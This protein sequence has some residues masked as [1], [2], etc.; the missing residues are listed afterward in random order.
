MAHMTLLVHPLSDAAVRPDHV[1]HPLV[2]FWGSA[3]ALRGA[4]QV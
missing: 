2:H 4:L 3:G 1:Q